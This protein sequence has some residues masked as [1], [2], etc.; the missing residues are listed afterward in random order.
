MTRLSFK[1]RLTYK[2][3]SYHQL[4]SSNQLLYLIVSVEFSVHCNAKGVAVVG[5]K[6]IVRGKCISNLLLGINQKTFKSLLHVSLVFHVFVI[7]LCY[8][9]AMGTKD[10]GTVR[11]TKAFLPKSLL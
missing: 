7:N 1:T 11:R 8:L 6:R 10:H 5:G 2:M 4:Y 9:Q 3:N